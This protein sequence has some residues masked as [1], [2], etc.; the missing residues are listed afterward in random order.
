MAYEL[1]LHS[2]P[3][4]PCM[5][6]SDSR[7]KV[8]RLAQKPGRCTKKTI[9]RHFCSLCSQKWNSVQFRPPG[10]KR[11]KSFT[12]TDVHC[13]TLQQNATLGT[14]GCLAVN[15][16]VLPTAGWRDW[17]KTFARSTT[18]YSFVLRCVGRTIVIS[19]AHRSS[20]KV[21]R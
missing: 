11:L 21:K 9:S 14:H 15:S 3:Y 12:P 17:A 20:C 8:N 2:K 6:A 18:Y 1:H 4:L 5:L 16:I 19:A 10:I 7:N 13:A